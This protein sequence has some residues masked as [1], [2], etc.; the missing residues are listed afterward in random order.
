MNKED[1]Q[2][3]LNYMEGHDYRLGTDKDGKP[4]RVDI[5]TDEYEAE[6]YSL[7]DNRHCVSGM[8][9]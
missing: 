4:V 3:L 6:P 5:N 8:M 2:I 7:D 1:A 9:S